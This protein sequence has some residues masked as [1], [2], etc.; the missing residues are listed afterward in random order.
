MKRS[1]SGVLALAAVIFAVVSVSTETS[2]ATVVVHPKFGG[3]ILGYDVDRGGTEGILSEFVAEP[4]G[5]VLAATETFDQSTGKIVKVL[6]KTQGQDDFATLGIFGGSVGLTLFQHGGT[7]SFL[8]ANPL[9]ANAFDGAW[10]PPLPSGF[11]LSRMSVSQGSRLAAGFASSFNAGDALVFATNVGRN[12]FGPLVSLASVIHGDEF[13]ISPALAFDSA[14]GTAILADSQGCPEP[15]CTTDIAIADLQTG[16]VTEFNDGLGVGTVDGI[17]VDPVRGIA[18]TTTLVDAGVEFYDLAH[19]T[20]FE[21]AIPDA[22]EL[23]AG[24]DVEFDALHHVFLVEQYSSTGDPN[25]PQPRIYVYDERGHVVETIP[26]QRIAISP[27]NIAIDPKTRTGFVDEIVEPAHMFLE[28][29]SF[30]Y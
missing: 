14:T 28:I 12:T 20:G 4:G 26:L 7:N 9:N 6:K 24:L 2:A 11:G 30:S 19:R 18:V 15:I 1:S 10:T 16:A 25:D 5:S 13:L 21:V 27:S 22:S 23:D 8:T 17:A 29:Q 3:Q